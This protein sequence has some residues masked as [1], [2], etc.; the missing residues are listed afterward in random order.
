VARCAPFSNQKSGER[1][2]SVPPLSHRRATIRL[3]LARFDSFR[4]RYRCGAH[5]E[6]ATPS[7]TQVSAP[8]TTWERP[9]HRRIQLGRYYVEVGL[10]LVRPL[11]INPE[12]KFESAEAQY[13]RTSE[14]SSESCPSEL[15]SDGCLSE[16][17]PDYE[18][19]LN[20]LPTIPYEKFAQELPS[21]CSGGLQE[22]QDP[23]PITTATLER[24]AVYEL[25]SNRPLSCGTQHRSMESVGYC[26][27]D[28][29]K[30]YIPYGMVHQGFAPVPAT[31]P[32][33]RLQTVES[34][35]VVPSLVSANNS[36]TP[37]PVSPVTPS[38]EVTRSV[39]A[40]Q[41]ADVSPIPG[42]TLPYQSAPLLLQQPEIN[43]YAPHYSQEV[44]YY[45]EP[46][47]P[48]GSVQVDSFS[49]IKPMLDYWQN[50]DHHVSYF[51]RDPAQPVQSV[52]TYQQTDQVSA[53]SGF[54]GWSSGVGRNKMVSHTMRTDR[55]DLASS[56][57]QNILSASSPVDIRAIYRPPNSSETPAQTGRVNHSPDRLDA[58]TT[59]TQS[60]DETS[61][62]NWESAKSR[63]TPP[64][65]K[66]KCN[67]C[68]KEFTGK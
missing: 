52:A 38:L 1:S 3:T 58:R 6:K 24:H 47:S 63:R 64:Y 19:L 22:L 66:E 48:F 28:S 2:E 62:R 7:T 32:L 68:G 11:T 10:V 18:D 53:V 29:Q 40:E 44:S 45:S 61:V 8:P 13:C 49:Y 21:D 14:L 23:A 9:K 16:L 39:L 60:N 51:S 65:P 12:V 50:N 54:S 67:V 34:L 5:A 55:T 25:D 20:E 59:A 42:T 27:F 26:S 37:S 56:W 30:D 43:E 46:A 17:P 4:N 41:Q 31:T 33:R 35:N 57:Q 15:S 36:H